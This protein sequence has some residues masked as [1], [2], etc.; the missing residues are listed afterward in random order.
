MQILKRG[1]T[2]ENFD[3]QAE[4][5]EYKDGSK[6]YTV[7]M[8]PRRREGGTARIFAYFPTAQT[9]LAILDEFIAGRKTFAEVNTVRES[10]CLGHTIPRTATRTSTRIEKNS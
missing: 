10:G 2:P 4:M 7:A 9:A 6:N 5:W 1:K 3:T 8:Y